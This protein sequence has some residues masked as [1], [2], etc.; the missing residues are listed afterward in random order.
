VI[1]KM[2]NLSITLDHRIVDGAMAAVPQHGH[3]HLQQPNLFLLE[4]I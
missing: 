2:M 4:G 3:R 1:R